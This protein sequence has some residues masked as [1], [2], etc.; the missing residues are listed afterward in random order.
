MTKAKI[1]PTTGAM[2]MKPA[3]LIMTSELTAPNP[4]AAI[5]APAKPPISVCEEDEG[6]PNHQVSKFHD[7][8]AI[9]PAKITTSPICPETTSGLTVFATVSATP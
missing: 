6:I 4:P 2:K 1:N 7:I 3:V 5:P 9:N 8:A